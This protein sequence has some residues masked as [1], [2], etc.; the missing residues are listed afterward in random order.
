MSALVLEKEGRPGNVEK[1]WEINFQEKSTDRTQE[2]KLKIWE[3]IQRK[4]DVNSPPRQKFSFEVIKVNSR[5]KEIDRRSCE[6]EFFAENLD[7]GLV[8]EMVYIPGGSFLMGS[9]ENEAERY[10]INSD[11]GPQH[12]VNLQPFYMSKYSI[13]Q[14]QYQAWEIILLTLKEENAQ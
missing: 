10:S 13:T 14:D 8:L 2:S 1:W 11:E 12:Q 9:P 4:K 3:F 7:S 5:G 6:A